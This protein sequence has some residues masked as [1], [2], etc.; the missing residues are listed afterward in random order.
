MAV[1]HLCVIHYFNRKTSTLVCRCKVSGYV[2]EFYGHC[3]AAPHVASG[4]LINERLTFFALLFPHASLLAP[5]PPVLFA[6]WWSIFVLFWASAWLIRSVLLIGPWL[7]VFSIIL[8]VK[9]LLFVCVC[10]LNIFY[11]QHLINF[12]GWFWNYNFCLCYEDISQ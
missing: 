7:P 10:T 1:K 4:L 9:G 6:G 12:I 5:D 3:T 8:L 2:L 11:F